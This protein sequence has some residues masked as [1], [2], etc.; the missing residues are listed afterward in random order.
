MR[1]IG[2]CGAYCKT[3]PPYND[4]YCKGCKQ[5]YENGE[6]NIDAAKCKMKV[7]CIKEKKI[8]TCADCTDYNTC[9]ILHEF[10]TKNGYKYK[11]YKQSLEFIRTHGY[12]EF[13]KKTKDWKH[14]YGPLK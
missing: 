9:T 2:C 12:K 11:K 14:A 3:C 6:R 4:G 1:Y 13:L 7:C 8:E 10:Q 5:G